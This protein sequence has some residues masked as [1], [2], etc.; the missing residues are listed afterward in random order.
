[1]H[2][3]IKIFALSVITLMTVCG[4]TKNDGDDSGTVLDEVDL[5]SGKQGQSV[6]FVDVDGDG[7]D[8]KIVGAPY[9]STTSE[10]GA[11]L[12][13]KGI[14]G[15]YATTPFMLLAGDDNTG[16]SF[17]D[18][19][20]VDADNKDDFAVGAINGSGDGE[21]DP[22]L[23]G[24]VIVY[25]GGTNGQ[26]LKK[27]AGEDPMDK[28]GF[29][30]A[31]GDLNNDGMNDIIIGAPYH[32]ND[33]ALY[34]G[35]AV[36]VYFGPDFSTKTSLY[37]TK[38]NKSLGWTVA[39]GQVNDDG[40]SDLLVSAGGRVLIYYGGEESFS[41]VV[42]GPD[43]TLKGSVSGF[44][45]ATAVI[46]DLD[47]DGTGELAIGG[48]NATINNNRDTGCIYIVKGT[49]S[50]T[51]DLGAAAPPADLMVRIDGA[52][53]FNRFGASIVSLGDIDGDDKPDFASG[54]PMAD[55]SAGDLSG[56][57][58]VFMGKD[59]SASTTLSNSMVLNGMVKNQGYGS[60]LAYR[61]GQLLIGAPRSNADTG[62]VSMIDPATGEAVSGGS[63]G[64]STGGGDACH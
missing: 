37:A 13:Y 5:A 7:T 14:T 63:S 39:A 27:L 32:T 42:D 10:T 9:A 25:K 31:S 3:K 11:V 55:V 19:G 38:N 61:S 34:Q 51:V 59:I 12:I 49:A 17:A 4:C 6:G 62:G 29:S 46:G 28:F 50:G 21:T 2:N 60:S 18:L 43:V 8:D 47:G 64:G 22:S 52:G 45:K 53:L 24:T 30:I 44:G 56:K 20:D 36:Y 48:P 41:P 54:A 40:I 26:V 35:G 1:M 57:V 23:S 16:F 15:G 33:P 58:Y